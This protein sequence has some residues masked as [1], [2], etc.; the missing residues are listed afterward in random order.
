MFCI[1]CAAENQHEG[2]FCHKCGKPL[3]ASESATPTP[4][5]E[6]ELTMALKEPSIDTVRPYAE[7]AATTHGL[8]VAY[9]LLFIVGG[10]TCVVLGF[11]APGELPQPSV[12][13]KAR[14]S[15]SRE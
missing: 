7:M 3:Y 5:T 15:A 13:A 6:S 14:P 10:L 9:G 12:G 8:I 2:K 1:Y 11:Y 4:P